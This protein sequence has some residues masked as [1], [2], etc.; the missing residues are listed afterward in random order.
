[1]STCSLSIRRLAIVAAVVALLGLET[2]SSIQLTRAAE[3]EAGVLTSRPRVAGKEEQ[4]LPIGQEVRTASRQRRRVA[5]GEG[6]VLYVGEETRVKRSGARRLTLASGVI[7]VDAAAG[8]TDE[9]FVIKTPDRELAM[10]AGRCGISAITRRNTNIVVTNIAVASGQ[11]RVN[12]VKTPL[13]GGQQ[14]A[15]DKD[16]AMPVERVSHLMEWT[17]D[18]MTEAEA[19]LVPPSQ[20]AGGRLIV[21]DPDGQQ[22][23]L[24]L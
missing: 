20:Y 19:P 8:R 10:R 5:L 14:L 12:G 3:P 16:Q 17:R 24:S 1:M 21:R 18:L 22:A 15:A 11:V 7:F 4:P 2:M 13:H 23:Q 9:D 6:S